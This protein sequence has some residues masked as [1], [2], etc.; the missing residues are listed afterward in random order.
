[1]FDPE[2][3]FVNV[4]AEKII[5]DRDSSKLSTNFRAKH[6]KTEEDTYVVR[7]PFNDTYNPAR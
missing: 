5:D 4:T 7:D 6:C 2:K 3:N 1:M